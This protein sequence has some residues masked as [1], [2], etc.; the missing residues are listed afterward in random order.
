M[1]PLRTPTSAAL[2][3]ALATVLLA[4]LAA[5]DAGALTAQHRLDRVVVPTS[6]ALRLELDA[7]QTDYS[8]TAHIALKVTAPT[9]S[10]ELNA[11]DLHLG[12]MELRGTHGTAAVKWTEGPHGLLTRHPPRQPAPGAYPLNLQL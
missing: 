12:K 2:L 11:E 6:E 1:R 3:A 8:G 4:A 9:D 10:F 7:A 5:P